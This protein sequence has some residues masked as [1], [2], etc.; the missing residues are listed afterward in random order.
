EQVDFFQAFLTQLISQLRMCKHVSNFKMAD[1]AKSVQDESSM[2]NSEANMTNKD[3]SFP[4]EKRY[5][6]QESN[7][8]GKTM[9]N[10]LQSGLQLDY[11]AGPVVANVVDPHTRAWKYMEETNSSQMLEILLTKLVY[12][13]PDCPV[14]FMIDEIENMKRQDI[15]RCELGAENIASKLDEK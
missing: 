2:S 4:Q 12:E 3:L 8:I 14:Q 9:L 15:K 11:S 6:L 7:E 1:E 13:R 10:S 5:S